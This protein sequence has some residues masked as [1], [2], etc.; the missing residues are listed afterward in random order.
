[1]MAEEFGYG[2]RELTEA[3]SHFS[4]RLAVMEPM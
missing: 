2:C 4:V 1:M 3:E